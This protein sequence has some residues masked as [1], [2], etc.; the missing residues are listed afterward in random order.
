MLNKVKHGL[1]RIKKRISRFWQW[2]LHASWKKRIAVI[3]VFL[4]I[5][6][7]L[8]N[9]FFGG[10]KQQYTFDTVSKGTITQLVTE[11]G[12][13][14]SSNETDV[15]SPTTGELAQ[16]YVKNGDHVN[17]GDKLFTIQSTAT[18]QEQAVAYANYEAALSALTTAQNNKVSSPDVGTAKKIS[19]RR[20][21]R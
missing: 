5:L 3:I 20:K 12:N 8:K 4:I 18:P 1:Q 10:Q 11:N 9:I 15:Y 13:V 16:I 19:K 7:L 17:Q 2:F 6:I 21:K 14:I